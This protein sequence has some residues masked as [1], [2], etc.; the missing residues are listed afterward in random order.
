MKSVIEKQ[1]YDIN[2]TDLVKGAEFSENYNFPLLNKAALIPNKLIP[3]NKI[4]DAKDKN[5]WV[6]FYIDDYR[7]N[8]LWNR[9]K[10]YLNILSGFNGVITPD[11]S[12]YYDMPI[13]MQI[14]NTYRNRAIGYWLQSQGINIIPNVRWSTEKSYDFAF[15]GLPK[16]GTVV[17]STHGAIKNRK[18]RKYFEKGLEKMVLTLDPDTIVVYS[19]CPDDIFLKYKESGINIIAFDN[20]IVETRKAMI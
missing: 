1:K 6:H 10:K 3:F 20:I 17:C 15:E 5:Q 12:L 13:A 19:Y 14:W 18:S 2:K 9:H 11:F 8:N 7:F 4:K 16:G